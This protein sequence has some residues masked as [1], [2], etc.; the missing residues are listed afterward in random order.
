MEQISVLHDHTDAPEENNE[1]YSIAPATTAQTSEINK[2]TTHQNQLQSQTK[3]STLDAI[4]NPPETITNLAFTIKTEVETEIETEVYEPDLEDIKISKTRLIKAALGF[5]DELSMT[6]ETLG[7]IGS[8]IRD[9]LVSIQKTLKIIAV[10][11]SVTMVITGLLLVTASIINQRLKRIEAILE[12]ADVISEEVYKST[13][14]LKFLLDLKEDLGISYDQKIIEEAFAEA[15]NTYHDGDLSI[16]TSV[17]NT[18]TL[19][20][21][22]VDFTIEKQSA[23]TYLITGTN[24]K[25][26]LVPGKYHLQIDMQKGRAKGSVTQDFSWGVLAINTNKS[27]FTPNDTAKIHL[28]VLDEKGDMVCNADLELNII[29]PKGKVTK[30]NTDDNSIIVNPECK[31]KKLVTKPDYETTFEVGEPGTYSM[32][33]KAVT[34]NGEY[35]ISDS[36]E[37]RESVP[38]DIERVSATRI[39]PRNDYPVIY[40]IVPNKDFEGVMTEK[41]PHDFKIEKL[42]KDLF[43]MFT[44]EKQFPYQ[45]HV[46]V[47]E[48]SLYY[49]EIEWYVNFKQ[50]ATYYLGYQYDSPDIS[51][52]FYLLGPSSLTP[53]AADTENQNEQKP[54]FTEARQWQ[55]AVDGTADILSAKGTLTT[56][57]STGNQSITGLG[58][59]PKAVMFFGNLQTGETAGSHGNNFFGWSDGTSDKSFSI[60]SADGSNA[61]SRYSQNYAIELRNQSGSVLAQATVSGFGNDGFT[62]NYTSVTSGYI[63]HYIAF[64][65]DDLTAEV[66]EEIVSSSPLTLS[67]SSLDPDI[68]FLGTA[69]LVIPATDAAHAISAFGVVDTSS[70]WMYSGCQGSDNTVKDSHVTDDACLSQIHA[71]ATDWSMTSCTLTTTGMTWSGSNSDEFG[72]L[73]LDLSGND[74]AI[75][76]FTKEVTGATN[77]TQSLTGW[78]FEKYAAVVGFATS[79]KTSEALTDDGNLSLGAYDGTA[80]GV[81]AVTDTNGS[82]ASDSIQN[83]DEAVLASETNA[84]VDAATAASNL[85]N[86]GVEFSWDPNNTDPYVV[87]YWAIEGDKRPPDPPTLHDVPFEDAEL[88]STTPNFEFTGEDPDGSADMIYEIQWD[89]NS[90]FNTPTTRVSDT[91]SGF[92]NTISGGDTNPFNENEKIRFTVQSGDALSNSTDNTTYFWRVRTKDTS[93]QGGSGVYGNWTDTNTFRINSNLKIDR[94]LQTTDEQFEN[95]DFTDSRTT[96]SD[97][98][99]TYNVTRTY[100]TSAGSNSYVIPTGV[101]SITIKAWGGGGGG[102]AGGSIGSGGSGG[103]GGFAQATLTVTPS[104]TIDVIVGGAGSGG[105]YPGTNSGGGGGGG[106]RTA[107]ERS[108]T[109][110]LI[111][112]GGGGGGGGDN[113]STAAGGAGGPGGDTTGTSGG[114]SG[115][116]TGGSGGTQASGG[117]GGSG[118]NN[119]AAGSSEQGGAGANGGANE[120]SGDGSGASGGSP[121]GGNAGTGNTGGYAGGGG[122]GD[123]YYGGGGGAGSVAGSAGGGGGGGGSSYLTGSDTDTQSGAGDLAGNYSD[124]DYAGTAGQGGSGGTTTNSGSAGNDGRVVIMYQVSGGTGAIMSSPVDYDW[125]PGMSSWSDFDWSEDETNGSISAKLYYSNTADCD[126]VVPNGSLSGNESGYTSGPIDISGLNT[127]TYNN[128]CVQASLTDSGGTPYLEDWNIQWG[129]DVSGTVYLADKATSA[130]TGNGGQCDSSTENISLRV[131]GGSEKTAYCSNSDGAYT[132]RGVQLQSGDSLTVYSTDGTDKSNRIYITDGSADTSI[133]LYKNTVAVSSLLGTTINIDDLT[134]YDSDTNNTDMLFD[135]DSGSP[136]TLTWESDIE[137]YIESGETFAPGGN[138]NGHDIQIEGRWTADTDETINVDGSFVIETGGSFTPSTSTLTF[139]ASSGTENLVTDGTGDIYNLVINDGGGSLIVEVEDSLTV[140]NDITITGGTL[141]TKSGENNQINLGGDWTNDD[142]FEPRSGTVVFDGASDATIDSGCTDED[143]CTNEDFYN[144]TIKKSADAKVTLSNTNLRV[145]NM[146]QVITGVFNQGDQN[147]R[148]E[149]T[150]ALQ[151]QDYGRY[152]SLQTGNLTLGGNVVNDGEITISANGQSCGDN[153]DINISSTTTSNRTWSGQG[154]FRIS[155]VTASYQTGSSI[156]HVGDGT[157]AGNNLGEW[158]FISCGVVEFNDLD[159]EGVNVE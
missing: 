67:D 146:L 155:D 128:I 76:I 123:G 35:Q 140:E 38:F 75:G 105:T 134:Y 124:D 56:P 11:A 125:V 49:K 39:Y 45:E 115:S 109:P 106:G 158:K 60:V 142:T 33:L 116:A 34:Q 52:Q 154:G 32:F 61:N 72:Y 25:N 40:K 28:A 83:N 21:Q 48:P 16:T 55:V 57:A 97:S 18:N 94:W 44:G 119:G 13:D 6:G 2:D 114:S 98:V 80:Q 108:G 96:G 153:D 130:T 122:G 132:I 31:S 89:D 159:L 53:K 112:A 107:I 14:E 88:W 137:F 77:A 37:T 41:V 22:P 91:H 147:V 157:D 87:G 65:G 151:I 12:N 136:D 78:G 58:F 42:E 138:V 68:I 156:I 17:I 110:L 84:S 8:E 148:T 30:L 118:N 90:S 70:Y 92:V 59:K 152:R 86:D 102:G 69:G 141:D 62:V 133:D 93:T 82:S 54:E 95:G 36:F 29:D 79:S 51:P 64:G 1:T 9:T 46:R 150:T 43:V 3:H 131:E 143:T 104:E 15:E 71:N 149:G 144:L 4:E 120:T 19:E 5:D 139:D 129:L 20:E 103:G 121:N 126:T 47:T 74:T 135:A 10:V 73:A 127:T 85:T 100:Y 145:G 7:A 111:A 66:G 27:V 117:A 50:G 63:I 101:T 24:T 81:I 26:T 113:S 23:T 99:E